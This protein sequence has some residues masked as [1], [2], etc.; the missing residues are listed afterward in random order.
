MS[1][2][3]LQGQYANILERI[4]GLSGAVGI[5]GGGGLSI[6]P[7]DADATF[8]VA[9][10]TDGILHHPFKF[11]TNQAGCAV[12]F[13]LNLCNNAGFEV[14]TVGAIPT[15]W[16]QNAGTFLLATDQKNDGANAAKTAANGAA[17]S[18][19]IFYARAGE[20]L[21]ATWAIRGNGA[22]ATAT[23]FLRDLTTQQALTSAGNWSTFST[24]LD[25]QLAA[26][27]KVPGSPLGFT[28]PDFATS[29][30]DLHQLQWVCAQS[31]AGNCWFDSLYVWPEVDFAGVFGHN[32]SQAITAQLYQDTAGFAGAGT[33]ISGAFSTIYQPSMYA[34]FTTVT[35]RYYKFVVSGPQ[36]DIPWV[37]Q[38]VLGQKQTFTRQHLY[39]DTRTVDDSGQ[40]RGS[41]RAFLTTDRGRR[42]WA[43]NYQFTT[44]ADYTTFREY[45]ER[46]RHGAYAG[47]L[48]PYD[49]VGGD[50]YVCLYG[51]LV[52]PQWAFT[53]DF[54]TVR[55][56][57][58]L[59]FKEDPYPTW[60]V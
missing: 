44:D 1:L 20:R 19:G 26:S 21:R 27:F 29:R 57:T 56:S 45:M 6:L 15:G 3:V 37:G 49:G 23:L 35:S 12:V 24:N 41:G 47:V 36:N 38:L 7:S 58:G 10:L 14:G 31:G 13:D 60:S 55:D 17:G 32:W 34:S 16:T 48:V 33:Q 39:G 5:S 18:S 50:S 4:G 52:D 28:V 46:S 53:H 11:G 22:A 2:L 51:R 8:G 40:V 54:L 59:V 42:I 25:N 9:N 43:P 30:S